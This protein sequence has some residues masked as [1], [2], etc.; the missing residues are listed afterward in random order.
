MKI[1]AWIIKILK[2][3]FT[4]PSNL[5]KNIINFNLI[6]VEYKNY[7]GE[8]WRLICPIIYLI[9]NH[10]NSKINQK[11]LLVQKTWISKRYWKF[12]L[13]ISCYNRY[14]ILDL[15]ILEDMPGQI[16]SF[17]Y[18]STNK[19]CNKTECW[20]YSIVMSNKKCQEYL[21]WMRLWG[22]L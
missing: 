22:N 6:Y 16:S 14:A 18:L 15:G 20:N 19:T 5:S 8:A 10:L 3:L 9:K 4:E 17:I 11:D 1:S 13:L 21:R 2:M 7:K 12:I